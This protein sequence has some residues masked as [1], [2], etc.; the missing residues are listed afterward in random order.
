M[1]HETNL[2]AETSDAKY[3]QMSAVR[4]TRQRLV[5]VTPEIDVACN[6]LSI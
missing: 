3:A 6:S 1:N 2:L 4:H 5:E